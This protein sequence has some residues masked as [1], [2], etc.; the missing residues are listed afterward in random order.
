[1]HDFAYNLFWKTCQLLNE[2]L[3]YKK[4]HR[5]KDGLVV[6]V[7]DAITQREIDGVTSSPTYANVLD[8]FFRGLASMKMRSTYSDFSGTRE[9]FPVLVETD[10]HDPVG[11]IEGFFYT[12]AMMNIDVYVKNA[13]VV[14]DSRVVSD[15]WV[16]DG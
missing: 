7:R 15:L 6:L 1:M 16:L 3:P 8:D 11:G 9:V 14:S 13:I 10:S 4:A 5:L 2:I 12:V